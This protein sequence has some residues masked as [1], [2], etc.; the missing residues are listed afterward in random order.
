MVDQTRKRAPGNGPLNGSGHACSLVHERCP[1]TPKV[2]KTPHR[3][4]SKAL[5]CFRR[6]LLDPMKLSRG[7]FQKDTLSSRCPFMRR[8]SRDPGNLSKNSTDTVRRGQTVRSIRCPQ[9]DVEDNVSSR[10]L[11]QYLNVPL[12]SPLPVLRAPLSVFGSE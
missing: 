9:Q 11:L 4:F 10:V 2:D 12:L 5:K 3:A 8:S 1:T 7:P 6:Q